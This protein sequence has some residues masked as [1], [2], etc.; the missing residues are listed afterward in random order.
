MSPI[1]R[2]AWMP[3]RGNTMVLWV[4]GAMFIVA[5]VVQIAALSARWP[6]WTRSE[7]MSMT[8]L[9]V[10]ALGVLLNGVWKEWHRRYK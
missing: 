10:V 1:G 6:W 4:R 5:A 8:A 2:P 7:Q 3:T 9:L